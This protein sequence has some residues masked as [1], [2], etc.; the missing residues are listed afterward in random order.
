[1][2]SWN[3]AMKLVYFLSINVNI[4][5]IFR[6]STGCHL[7]PGCTGADC[8]GGIGCC[9]EVSCISVCE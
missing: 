1:M 7:G 4:F 8:G 2:N 6:Y 9:M 3:N 5:P